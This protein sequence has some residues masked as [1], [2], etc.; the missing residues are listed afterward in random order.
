MAPALCHGAFRGTPVRI[1]ALL[2]V[3]VVLIA[4]FAP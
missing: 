3:A 2:L 1:A 4:I